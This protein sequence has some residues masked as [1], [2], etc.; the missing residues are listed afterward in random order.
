MKIVCEYCDSY[1]EVDENMKCP[2]C[3]GPLGT[4]IKAEQ[5]RIEQEKAAEAQREADEAAREAEAKAQE[6]KEDHISEIIAG[7]TSVATAIITGKSADDDDKP[8]PSVPPAHPD[9]HVPH[10]EAKPPLPPDGRETLP[11]R[12]DHEIMHPAANSPAH[13]PQGK[14]PDKHQKGRSGHRDTNHPG[15]NRKGHR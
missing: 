7:I 11:V 13:T 8:E 1:V 2:L 9:G 5:E 6:A 14:Q 3:G 4:A 15:A 10:H 12:H